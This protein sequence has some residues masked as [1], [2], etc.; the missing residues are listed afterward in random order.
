[1]FTESAENP[2]VFL[3]P[4]K[5]AFKTNN[6]VPLQL[7][8]EEAKPHF[9]VKKTPI[10]IGAHYS[11]LCRVKAGGMEYDLSDNESLSPFFFLYN[12]QAFLWKNN[13]VIHLVEKFLPSG[14]M[15]VPADEWVNTLN[16]FMFRLP[17]TIKLILINLWYRK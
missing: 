16:Q 11:I 2:F 17:K 13:E 10:A 12:R 14:K 1:M 15:S 3:L 8:A 4:D 7:Q 9:I 5:K 6:L